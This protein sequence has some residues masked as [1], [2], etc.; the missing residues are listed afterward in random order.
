MI[1]NLPAMWK[2]WVQFLGWKDLLEK[3]MATNFSILAGRIPW[4]KEPGRL[5]SM[6]VTSWTEY[7]Y[8]FLFDA[9]DELFFNLLERN[10]SFLVPVVSTLSFKA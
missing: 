4:T 3:E 9:L 5:Q 1:K 6:R 8:L 7:L 10:E 2:S